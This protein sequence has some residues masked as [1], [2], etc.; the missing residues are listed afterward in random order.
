MK[1]FI[2]TDDNYLYDC[3]FY[4]IDSMRYGETQRSIKYNEKNK[5]Y[6]F[7]SKA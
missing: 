7:Q 1:R 5:N 6:Y 4:G 3:N 2:I